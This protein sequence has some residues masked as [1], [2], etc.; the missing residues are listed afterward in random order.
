MPVE[1]AKTV[2]REL[3]TE[4]ENFSHI[5]QLSNRFKLRP[6]AFKTKFLMHN[7]KARF[8]WR[9][10]I[11]E[12]QSYLDGWLQCVSINDFESL[13]KMIAD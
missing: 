1:I 6:E 12:L 5:R 4:A 8:D 13:K 7:K 2:I 10:L 3:E 9:N 11:F